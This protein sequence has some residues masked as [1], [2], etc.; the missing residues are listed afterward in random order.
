METYLHQKNW[1][2]RFI[3]SRDGDTPIR[4]WR[5]ATI[6]AGFYFLLSASWILF[7]GDLIE[8]MASNARE[9]ARLEVIKGLGF[10]IVTTVLFFCVLLFVFR[11]V[12][13]REQTIRAQQE[14]LMEAERAAIAGVV[15]SSV[16]HDLKNAL[17]SA[18]LALDELR[19]VDGVD[20]EVSAMMESSFAVMD[21]LCDDLMTAGRAGLNEVARSFNLQQS[22]SR[23]LAFA[24]HHPS[25]SR[26]ELEVGDL[27]AIE[28]TGSPS[29]LSRAIVNAVINAAEAGAT[30]ICVS[31]TQSEGRTE[32]CIDD[33][34]PGLDPETRAR[35]F[36]PWF[37][38][39]KNGTGLGLS[40]LLACAGHHDGEVNVMESPLGGARF[41]LL[42]G[43]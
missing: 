22:L 43:R 18:R 41:V 8:G 4:Y 28:I 13:R 32:V 10:V 2:L 38:T 37:T 23:A 30:K 20:A 5:L 9:L 35:V 1:L 3:L 24:R 15:S 14:T 7:S 19:D 27:P 33:D 17:A 16:S 6:G 40:S 11:E 26:A 31:A 36:E 21:Q 12:A 34:G 39:K 42:L 25:V 29:L